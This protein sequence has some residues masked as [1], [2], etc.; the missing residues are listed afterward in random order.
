MEYKIFLSSPHLNKEVYEGHYVKEA[1]DKNC[2][3][4]VKLPFNYK[5]EKNAK[6]EGNK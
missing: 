4:I 6:R 5:K 2:I 3:S 1:F